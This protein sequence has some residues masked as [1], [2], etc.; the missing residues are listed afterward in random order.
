MELHLLFWESTAECN[1]A[2]GHCRRQVTGGAMDTAR[3]FDLIDQLAAFASPMLVVS[4]GEPLLRPDLYEVGAHAVRRGLAAALATNGV[5]VGE[6]E[7]RAIR[8]AGFR[9]VSVSL[10]GAD[11][12]THDALR[13]APGAFEAAVMGIRR[14]REAGLP[15]QIN[16]TLTRLSRGQAGGIHRLACELGC[17][18]LHYFLFI[19]TGCGKSLGA[20]H[21]L[22]AAEY[23]RL[24][25]DIL[26]LALES[27][28][29]VRTT[30]APQ[31]V[32]LLEGRAPV[33]RGPPIAS[34]CLAGRSV[35]F[36]SSTG[37]VFPCGYL[38]VPAGD[39]A[40]TSLADIWRD[41]PVFRALR[42]PASLKG[43]CAACELQAS[44]GGCRARAQARAGDFLGEDPMC[45]L[46]AR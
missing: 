9:R 37:R 18:A 10:D 13:G 27:P 17:V 25:K 12:A 38:P 40:E 19:P 42:D 7:A 34:G 21:M 41:S 31:M 23:E 32:R 45:V 11:A 1:L 28:I 15:V 39:L 30:C 5:L 36:V 46:A 22:E 14:L 26:A 8:R 2:C 4:G 35:C 43:A 16:A 3:A 33:R 6:M 44:C 20:E 24:L 29:H